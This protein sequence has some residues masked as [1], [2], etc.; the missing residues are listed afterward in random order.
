MSNFELKMIFFWGGKYLILV[1]EGKFLE[2]PYYLLNYPCDPGP[3]L[4]SLM[5]WGTNSRLSKAG[6]SEGGS[7]QLDGQA[8]LKNRGARLVL[9]KCYFLKKLYQS[10]WLLKSSLIVV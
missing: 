10:T 2:S 3:G 1:A 4:Q 9:T 6:P 7:L 5:V 8:K